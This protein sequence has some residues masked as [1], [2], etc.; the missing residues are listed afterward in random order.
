MSDASTQHGGE[1]AVVFIRPRHAS[2]AKE[3]DGHQSRGELPSEVLL[4]AVHVV[5]RFEEP[6]GDRL[7]EEVVLLRHSHFG[8]A[9]LIRQRH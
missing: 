5:A 3:E 1:W 8:G 7:G 9:S 6:V 2:P 4:A